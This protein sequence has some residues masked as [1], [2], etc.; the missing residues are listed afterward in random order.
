VFTENPPRRQ[1][2]LFAVG[3]IFTAGLGILLA[4]ASQPARANLTDTTT[5]SAPTTTSV[6]TP[7]PAPAPAPAPMPVPKP[8]PAPK[9]RASAP[10]YS[11]PATTPTSSATPSIHVSSVPVR[12]ITRPVPKQRHVHQRR[13]HRHVKQSVVPRAAAAPKSPDPVKVGVAGARVERTAIASSAPRD[14][15]AV[16]FLLVGLLFGALLLVLR[17]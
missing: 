9:E 3:V 13:R 5:E 11:P 6:P 17:W 12:A 8:A 15:L 16:V 14:H 4:F 10:S 1:R 7:D 2:A